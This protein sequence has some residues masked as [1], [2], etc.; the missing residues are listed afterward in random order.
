ML[1]LNY[2]S[3]GQGPALIILHGLFGSLDNWTTHARSLAE[4]YS[5]YTLDLRNHGR[6]PHSEVW[7]Y[8]AMADDL[9][10]FMEQHGIYRAHLLGHSMG[11]K[12]AMQ[13]A[14]QHPG[15]IDK[16]VVADMTPKAYEP[17][18]TAILAA[19][20]AIDLDQI[21]TRQEAEAALLPRIAQAGV[22]QFLLKSLAR[23][24]E[25]FRWKFNLPVIARDYA[26][27]L[28]AVELDYPFDHPTLFVYGKRSD[29]LTEGDIP[30]IRALFPA[31]RFEGIADAGHW[32]HAD[33]P[34]TFLQIVQDFLVG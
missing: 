18:H 31:A 11:G 15:H 7:T 12:V 24:G 2:K 19:L 28:A 27:M 4:A 21:G 17:H 16:L 8:E 6:S 23:E 13:F 25:A 34:E 5:V 14:G 26:Q 1:E 29:Y 32:L 3:Y 33:T 30:A 10:A 22:R 20:Q 9:L